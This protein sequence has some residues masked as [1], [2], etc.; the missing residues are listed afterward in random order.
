MYD[1][2]EKKLDSA[3]LSNEKL[4]WSFKWTFNFFIAVTY[5]CQKD[6]QILHC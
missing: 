6:F 2:Y 3:N 4:A 1:F 5:I